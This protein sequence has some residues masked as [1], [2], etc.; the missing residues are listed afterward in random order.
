[1]RIILIKKRL[2]IYKTIDVDFFFAQNYRKDAKPSLTIQP[3]IN[4][5]EFQRTKM[6]A[7]SLIP[8]VTQLRGQIVKN[9]II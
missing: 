3:I 4:M 2:F 7:K 6:T 8:D 5:S 9:I 1:M